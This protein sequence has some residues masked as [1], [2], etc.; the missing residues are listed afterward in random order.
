[1]IVIMIA[2][3]YLKKVLCICYV[4]LYYDQTRIFV[5]SKIL[6]WLMMKTSHY[7]LTCCQYELSS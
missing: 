6:H 3:L 1:M 2:Y 4:I 7:V 5:N